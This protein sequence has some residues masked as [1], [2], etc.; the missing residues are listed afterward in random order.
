MLIFLNRYWLWLLTPLIFALSLTAGVFSARAETTRAPIAPLP[1]NTPLPL[2]AR[3]PRGL[4]GVV[5][6]IEPPPGFLVVRAL[7]GRY[8]LVFPTR[9]LKLRLGDEPARPRDLR[10][11]DRVIVVGKLRP[12]K[13]GI[14]A[15][16]ITILPRFRFAEG[17]ASKAWL[18]ENPRTTA[19]VEPLRVFHNAHF[20]SASHLW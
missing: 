18:L 3:P 12:D 20:E 15:T 11:G 13:G 10:V 17:A 16:I 1:P 8:T 19:S 9:T 5:V 2:A 14:D 6:A 4:V 7:N